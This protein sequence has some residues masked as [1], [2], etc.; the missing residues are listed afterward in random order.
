MPPGGEVI[1]VAAQDMPIRICCWLLR[2]SCVLDAD[3]QLHSN[4]T[5]HAMQRGMTRVPEEAETLPALLAAATARTVVRQPPVT[6]VRD[7]MPGGVRT[8]E[9]PALCCV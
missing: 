6:A 4:G 7:A 2:S 8:T 5:A 9:P 1:A 3:A